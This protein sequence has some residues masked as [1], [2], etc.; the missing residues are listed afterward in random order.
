MIATGRQ[1]TT[2][3]LGLEAAGIVTNEDGIVTDARL[4]TTNQHVFA[5][6]DAVGGPRFTHVAE[7]QAGIVVRNICFKLPASVN[8]RSLPWVTY[9]EP[10]LA[11][12]GPTEAAARKHVGSS[13][14]VVEWRFA[15]VD[16]AVTES[17][18][19]GLIRVVTTR[20]GRILG[21]SIV[22]AHAGELIGLWVL[23]VAKGMRISS[24]ANMMTPYPTL[25]E[26]SKRAA[27]D[28][29]D[30]YLFNSTTKRVVGLLQHLPW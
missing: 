28:W 24:I 21:A 26:V 4:R 9:S 22:G 15:D 19:H 12:A 2:D 16:R 23:A 27:G 29:L 8:Y 3:G 11:Q 14:R 10:E 20:T 6:G 25:G 7:Y 1:A 13:V 5:V 18:T 30:P 17:A